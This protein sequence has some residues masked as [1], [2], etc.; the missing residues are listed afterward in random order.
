LFAV[1][2][3]SILLLVPRRRRDR[4]GLFE[5]GL[6]RAIKVL[7]AGRD[8]SRRDL[9]E[10]AGLSYSYLAEIENG[11]KSPSSRALDALASGLGL[12]VGDLAA[13]AE[14]WGEP[15]PG[16]EASTSDLERVGEA[17]TGPGEPK[18]VVSGFRALPVSAKPPGAG[19]AVLGSNLLGARS[20]ERASSMR[21]RRYLDLGPQRRL[22]LPARF[23]RANREYDVPRHLSEE[24]VAGNC[25]AFVGAG[26]S[27]A[28]KLPDW[29]KLLA[30]VAAR[31]GVS[32]DART[33]VAER[34]KRRSAYALDE[35]AQVLED[36]LGRPRLLQQLRALLGDPPLTDAM[37]QRIRW[38][39][40]IPF[41]SILT[42]N[43][44]GLLEG[45][46]PDHAAYR[47][48]LRPEAH[49]WW[50]P[51]YW[52]G[53]DGAITLKLHGDLRSGSDGPDGIVLTRRDYR[54]R[55]YED[56]AYETFLRAVMA[57][58]T[59]LY[60][61]LSF[62]DAY[63]NEL[64]SEILALLGQDRESA[65]VAYAIVNDVPRET[66][67][68]FRR[69]EGIEI[70]SYDT[71]GGRSFAGFDDYLEIIHDATSPLLR[72]ARHLEHKRILWVD[73][74][75]E[76]NELAFEHLAQAARMSGREGTALVTMPTPEEGLRELEAAGDGEP[77]DLVLTHWGEPEP[78][79]GSDD[80]P[81]AVRLLTG[82]R[83]R[84]LRVPV[85]V[86]AAANDLEHRKRTAL[87]LGAHGYRHSFVS[88]YRTIDDI[89]APGEEPAVPRPPART[90]L[91]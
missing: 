57:T 16:P 69:H 77:F 49:R 52:S 50:E 41:R 29:G 21:P 65:P 34:V 23:R 36:E 56:P 10:R 22:D 87:G 70:L 32:K 15:T 38:L 28:A 17:G 85:V 20:P 84:D 63:L 71:R 42:T 67:A 72:F 2:V 51:R 83:V 78:R 88:L 81:A 35:A 66:R 40:G 61:G 73:P 54:R 58:T 5:G 8:L 26:F 68:H 30:L 45:E 18:S 64:R 4:T 12:S 48:A 27:G 74:H 1:S 37:G 14:E 25:V 6:G 31:S 89:L 60:M 91:V 80:R 47:H 90:R 43:F 9:A 33:H 19:D 7:R 24:I 82:I 13:A 3:I 86:F 59:V 39:R 44:D 11:A 79:L 75:P 46:T 62:E 55:L 76:N 53:V